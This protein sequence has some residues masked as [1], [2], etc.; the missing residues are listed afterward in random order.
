MSK[1]PYCKSEVHIEDFFE[2]IKYLKGKTEIKSAEFKG[3]I[4]LNLGHVMWTCPSC[5][6]I[7]GFSERG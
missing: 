3:E 5:D 6:T 2:K 4:I 1:C 7:L